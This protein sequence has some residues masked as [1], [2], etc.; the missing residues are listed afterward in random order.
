MKVLSFFGVKLRITCQYAKKLTQD[1]AE[2][3]C[4]QYKVL[5]L[6]DFEGQ[7]AV[8]PEWFTKVKMQKIR[9]WISVEGNCAYGIYDNEILAA[10]GWISSEWMVHK[11]KLLKPN[12]GYLWD[13]YTHPLYRGRGLHGKLVKIRE[14]NL[15]R[16]GKK[17]E[18]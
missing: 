8:N 11:E 16:L 15:R 7:A 5:V 3:T 12:V 18:S 13:D 1:V 4:L 17:P 14:E 2:K 6:D 9:Q 10:Y